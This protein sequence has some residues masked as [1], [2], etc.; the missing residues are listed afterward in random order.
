[1]KDK[2]NGYTGKIIPG[3]G[4]VKVPNPPKHTGW[5]VL[6]DLFWI[7]LF[8]SGVVFLATR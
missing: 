1:M 3:V 5:S 8:I 6:V 4:Y 7:G 2:I